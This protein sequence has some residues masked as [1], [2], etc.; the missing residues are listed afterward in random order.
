MTCSSSSKLKTMKPIT[1]QEVM[2][3]LTDL[4]NEGEDLS[5]ITINYRYDD[6][7]D[8]QIVRKLEEDL[9]DQETNSRL[10]SIVFLTK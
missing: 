6:D 7:S 1:A 2:D 5:S 9:F 4:E 10:T 8:V 3:Y